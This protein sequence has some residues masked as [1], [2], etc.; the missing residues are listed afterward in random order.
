[1]IS[2]KNILIVLIM[3]EFLILR[4]SLLIFY[5]CRIMKLD[6]FIVYYLVFRVCESVIGLRLL[7]MIV[8]FYGDELYDFFNFKKF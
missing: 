6:F 7:V 5:I 3:I 1:M 2:Y 4:I 8:R